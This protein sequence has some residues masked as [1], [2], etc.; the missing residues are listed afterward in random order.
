M[1]KGQHWHVRPSWLA[2]LAVGA[3][4]LAV[5][6]P[7][8]SWPQLAQRHAAADQQ[9]LQVQAMA[10]QAEQLRA[11]SSAPKVALADVLQPLLAQ[12]STL[13]LQGDVAALTLQAVPAAQWA[14]A[15]QRMRVQ[16]GARVQSAQLRVQAGVVSGQVA[17]QLPAAQP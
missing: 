3:V 5:L 12:G 16:S 9:L 4:L 10:A 11:A 1:P 13:Q 7:L 14:Q 15:L 17:V 2:L 8:R 6:W